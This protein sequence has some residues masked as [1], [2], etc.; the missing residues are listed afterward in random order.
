[1]M[2]FCGGTNIIQFNGE[3]EF[4]VRSLMS[5][6]REQVMLCAVIICMP[7][8]QNHQAWM[9]EISG[10]VKKRLLV[11]ID[12]AL[13]T[14]GTTNDFCGNVDCMPPALQQFRDSR[15]RRSAHRSDIYSLGVALYSLFNTSVPGS[16]VTRERPSRPPARRSEII[17]KGCACSANARYQSAQDR[18][19]D[20]PDYWE[21]GS[22]NARQVSLR[23]TTADC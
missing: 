8:Y 18:L 5:N 22:A 12:R 6:R 21:H 15:R 11:G 9:K 14:S 19:T 4:L 3:P 1:M 7:L 2:S 10:S 17:S 16:C 13:A 23:G 20:L